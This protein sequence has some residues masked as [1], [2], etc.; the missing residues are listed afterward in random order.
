[1][2]I[3]YLEPLGERFTGTSDDVLAQIE[4]S[5]RATLPPDF[6]EFQKRYGRC[7]FAG[8]ARLPLSDGR[9][10]PISNFFGGEAE[11]G[12]LVRTLRAHDGFAEEQV[13]PV[14]HDD[15]DNLFVLDG[16]RS[17]GVYWIDYYSYPVRMHRVADSFREF[18]ESIEVAPDPPDEAALDQ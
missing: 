14:A 18:I 12:D 9:Y 15:F 6:R 4:A 2:E 8:D 1:L 16:K 13:V 17:F 10:A 5:I 11:S 3:R 7:G